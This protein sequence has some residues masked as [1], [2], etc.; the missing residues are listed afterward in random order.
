MKIS[1]TYKGM[2][3][4]RQVLTYT[5]DRPSNVEE[6]L[7]ITRTKWEWLANWPYDETEAWPISNGPETCGLCMLFFSK[8]FE[9][10]CN[11]AC[12]VMMFT[13][14]PACMGTPFVLWSELKSQ[15]IA[16]EALAYLDKVEAYYIKHRVG[17][18]G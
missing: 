13:W 5:G 8:A 17:E 7:A 1:F 15:A 16:R 14:T 4:G 3:S 10:G 6:A 12:P 2:P 18:V 9:H 11:P